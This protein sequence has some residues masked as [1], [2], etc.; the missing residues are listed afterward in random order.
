[1]NF[2][3]YSPLHPEPKTLK[4]H[5]HHFPSAGPTPKTLSFKPIHL[6]HQPSLPSLP[7]RSNHFFCV[8]ST[9]LATSLSSQFPPAPSQT[10]SLSNHPSSS[11]SSHKH[12]SYQQNQSPTV[13]P[14]DF[15]RVFNENGIVDGFV[16]SEATDLTTDT[17]SCSDGWAEDET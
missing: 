13:L 12:S 10:H 15:D 9:S 17:I 8:Q 5:W 7:A 3:N 2:I 6:H 1:M 11:T 14:N 16:E 4:A